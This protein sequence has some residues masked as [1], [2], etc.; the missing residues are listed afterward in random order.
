MR[1]FFDFFAF[2]LGTTT[3][4]KVLT[5]RPVALPL[6][7]GSK[8]VFLKKALT[9]WYLPVEPLFSGFILSIDSDRSYCS[10]YVF[11]SSFRL[12]LLMLLYI[13]SCYARGLVYFKRG[14]YAPSAAPVLDI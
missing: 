13:C 2:I 8:L 6:T 12:I 9:A 4:F 10:F 11:K 14:D 3:M 7:V 5:V 1:R